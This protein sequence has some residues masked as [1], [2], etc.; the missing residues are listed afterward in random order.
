MKTWYF[1]WDHEHGSA[2]V[3]RET[4]HDLN[5]PDGLITF[6]R[7]IE[8]Q[9]LQ[10]VVPIYWREMV[11]PNSAL[12][13]TTTP[14]KECPMSHANHRS[15]VEALLEEWQQNAKQ[16]KNLINCLVEYLFDDP[17]WLKTNISQVDRETLL[18]ASRILTTTPAHVAGQ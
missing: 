11:S 5:T 2:F 18:A 7:E 3:I 12:D 14:T 9:R 17:Y 6:I 10:K 16:A 4:K 1:A 13:S 15:E 8:S